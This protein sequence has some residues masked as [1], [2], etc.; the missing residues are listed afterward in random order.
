M[1]CVCACLLCSCNCSADAITSLILSKSNSG[2]F[3]FFCIQAIAVRSNKKFRIG[4][5]SDP[6]VFMAWFLNTIHADLGGTQKKNSS[7]ISQTF[8]GELVVKVFK[9]EAKDLDEG[10]FFIETSSI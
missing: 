1:V 2:S 8:Q 3:D 4:V 6:I 7:I 9:D 5:Q 10:S